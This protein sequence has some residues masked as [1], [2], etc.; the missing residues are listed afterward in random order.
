MRISERTT[1]RKAF[2]LLEIIIA[3]SMLVLILGSAFGAYTAT[4]RSLAHS[5][6]TNAL[7]QQ[8]GIFLQSIASEIRCCYA[9]YEDKSLQLA[10]KT[11][12]TSEKKQRQQ[13]K[14]SLFIGGKVSSGRS[15]L[16]FVTSWVDPKREYSLGGLAI[17][18]YML[19]STKNKLLRSKRRYIG[20]FEIRRDN[21]NWL[22]ILENVQN[23]TIEYFDGKDWFKE[24]DSNDK[25]GLLPQ[26]VKISLVMQS[27]DIGSLSFE[28]TVRIVCRKKQSVGVT[29]QNTTESDKILQSIGNNQRAND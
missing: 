29:I 18:E 16:R 3:L 9:G 22:V 27:E 28:S 17:I 11:I 4:A 10:N 14:P 21:Y 5:K 12:R 24:W 25:E 2:T 23:V 13:A 7:Q 8:A 19:D 1:A 26:A 15:I 6:Q 20:G